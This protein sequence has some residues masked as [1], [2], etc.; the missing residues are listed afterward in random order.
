MYLSYNFFLKTYKCSKT[1]ENR[2]FI[3]HNLVLNGKFHG[4]GEY[5]IIVTKDY[6][7]ASTETC[8]Q[9]KIFP[10]SNEQIL[11]YLI[12]YIGS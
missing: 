1:C 8:L 2:N 7:S 3:L 11:L 6:V 9:W 5:N 12:F 10:A 4:L